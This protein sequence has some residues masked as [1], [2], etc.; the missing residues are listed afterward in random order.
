M[1]LDPSDPGEHC[2]VSLVFNKY[3]FMPGHALIIPN[4]NNGRRPQFLTPALVDD[5]EKIQEFFGKG[6]IY[7]WNSRG[8]FASV[9]HAHFQ[10]S[11]YLPLTVEEEIDGVIQLTECPPLP[12]LT[13][14]VDLANWPVRVN[15]FEDSEGETKFEKLKEAIEEIQTAFIGK[16]LHGENPTFYNFICYGDKIYFFTRRDQA[17]FGTNP[18]ER[19][20]GTGLGW[21]EACGKIIITSEDE[22]NSLTSDEIEVMMRAES[23]PWVFHSNS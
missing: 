5:L 4:R 22:F 17:L 19:K 7:A 18:G 23:V 3:P 9:N 13:A 2:T 15:V 1:D 16:V 12:I 20:F 14:G 10:A 21:P 11:D 6:K 8:A